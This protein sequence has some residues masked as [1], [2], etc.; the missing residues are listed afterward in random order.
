MEQKKRIE[1]I[2][3]MKGICIILVVLHHGRALDEADVLL[4]NLVLGRMPLYFFLSGLFFKSYGGFATF[5][6]RKFCLLV[7]PI[8]VFGPLGGLMTDCIPWTEWSAGK[9]SNPARW[10]VY[11][12]TYVNVPLWFLR[13][14]FIGSLIMYG[15]HSLSARLRLGVAAAAV[16]AV[17]AGMTVYLLSP[18]IQD[19]TPVAR[20]IAMRCGIFH[21]CELLP[22]LFAGYLAGR[23]GFTRIKP[24]M[25]SAATACAVLAVALCLCLVLP[26]GGSVSWYNIVLNESYA[27]IIVKS[28][29]VTAFVWAVS[30]LLKKVPYISYLGR[31]SIVVLVTHYPLLFMLQ[32]VLNVNGAT[33]AAIVLAAMPVIVYACVRWLP[34]ACARKQIL[35]W[36]DGGIHLA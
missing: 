30:F 14:L 9:I 13:A 24:G 1:Y 8:I 15:L 31:Y 36:R 27:M 19:T 22:F 2:D 33:A 6:T 18:V 23:W 21:A 29:S 16:L 25:K 26:T 28:I 17:G 11:W 12:T 10:A 3:L 34:W 20:K 32:R 4:H 7:V 35:E 5:A